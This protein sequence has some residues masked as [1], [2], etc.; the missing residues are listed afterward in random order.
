M[1]Y[2]GAQLAPWFDTKP[3]ERACHRMADAGGERMTAL[4]KERTPVGHQPFAENYTPG[5][6]RESIEKKITVVHVRKGRFEYESGTETSVDY[7]P[8]VENGTG[9][10]GPNHAR[11]EI[12]PKNPDGWLRFHDAHGNAIFAKRVMHPGSPGAHMFAI[13]A[14]LTEAEFDR[15]VA[16]SLNEWAR[17]QERVNHS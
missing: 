12:K 3:V 6:L 13:G 10:W 2:R 1:G 14:A 5:R 15:I 4:V 7:A 11:Y 9:L 8:F 17:E 16:P